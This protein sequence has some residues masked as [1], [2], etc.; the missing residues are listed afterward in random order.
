MMDEFYKGAELGLRVSGQRQQQEQ[1]RTN[2][3]ERARQFDLGHEIQVDSHNLR[4]REFTHKQEQSVIENK[5]RI[6][7]TNR[8]GLLNKEANRLADN[9]I[10]HEPALTNYSISLTEWN[11]ETELPPMPQGLPSEQRAEAIEMQREASARSLSGKMNKAQAEYEQKM[12]QQYFEGFK[13]MDQNA[14][15]LITQDPNT[16]TYGY[17]YGAY[18]QARQKQVNEQKAIGVMG[19]TGQTP[20]SAS[21]VDEYTGVRTQWGQRPKTMTP[22]Q[23]KFDWMTKNMKSFMDED[24]V[25]NTAGMQEAWNFVRGIER[26]GLVLDPEDILNPQP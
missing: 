12:S 5:Y 7:A 3:A 2:L 13:W 9:K 20:V 11:G 10:T 26:G 18:L 22:E 15:F 6:A 25:L 4:E 1:F 16:G 23:Q 8:I 19:Q 21:H 14:P 17:D 24:G